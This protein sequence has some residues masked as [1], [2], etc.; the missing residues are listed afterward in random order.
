MNRPWPNEQLKRYSIIT[1]NIWQLF[2][3]VKKGSMIQVI[4][5]GFDIIEYLAKEGNR[6]CTL[7]EIAATAGLN[8]GTCANIIKTLVERGYDE[9][10]DGKGYRLGYMFDKLS[11]IN[12]LKNKL[13]EISKVELEKL[14][15]KYNENTLLAVLNGNI[16]QAIY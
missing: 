13:V 15:D 8:V 5:R 1:A 10:V 2:I 6:I 3:F 14:A 9:K 12:A 11:S 16:R 4:G 7:T